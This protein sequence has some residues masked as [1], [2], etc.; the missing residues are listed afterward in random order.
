[1]LTVAVPM[2]TVAVLM[3]VLF[4]LYLQLRC[5]LSFHL[6]DI[7]HGQPEPLIRHAERSCVRTPPQVSLSKQQQQ[8]C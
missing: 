5:A 2:P 3:A 8:C 7:L 1:M 4:F 6:P